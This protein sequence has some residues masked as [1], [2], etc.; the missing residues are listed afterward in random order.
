VSDAQSIVQTWDRRLKDAAVHK[1]SRFG[2][3][4]ARCWRYYGESTHAFM[5]GED[6]EELGIDAKMAK[7]LF[8][9]T[10]AKSAEYVAI[11]APYIFHKVPARTV[12]PRRPT[13]PPELRGFFQ[14]GTP[15]PLDEQERRDR[16][17]AM[18]M[19]WWLNF[20]PSEFDL[21][22]E[23]QHSLVEGMVKGRGL[24][25]HEVFDGGHGP[26]VGSFYI[27]VDDL[28]ID[29][30]AVRLKD[31][32][33]IARKRR[34]PVWQVAREFQY[35]EQKLRSQASNWEYREDPEHE[36]GDT[37]DR[38]ETKRPDPIR[39]TV[40]YYEIYSACGLGHR[41]H[42]PE[43]SEAEAYQAMEAMGDH[44]YLVICPGLDEPLNL[45]SGVMGSASLQ[46]EITQRLAWPIP[47]HHDNACPWLF[48][49]L[50][51]RHRNNC[52]WPMS[53]L[54]PALPLQMFLNLAFSFLMGR[55][56]TT[57]RD[58]IC[59]AADAPAAIKEAIQGGGDREVVYFKDTPSGVGVDISK[60][61]HVLQFP[62]VNKDIYAVIAAAEEAFEKATGMVDL[63]Y[64]SQGPRQMRS[65]AEAQIRQE[66]MTSRPDA[67]AEQF[68]DFMSRAARKEAFATRLY[69]PPPKTLFG[70]E[71]MGQPSPQNPFGGM[72]G[73]LT[74]A[75]AGLVNTP[76]PKRAAL[77]L[78][79]TV[80]AN[81]GRKPNRQRQIENITQAMPIVM[82]P[83]LQYYQMT[84]DPRPFNGMIRKWGEAAD[85]DTA[86]M[87]LPPLPPPPG[88]PPGA[89]QPGP[90]MQGTA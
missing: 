65:S 44:V 37:A 9:A 81:S 36:S 40:E 62:G 25:W 85:M 21:R 24:L 12:Q 77:E 43:S 46:T 84:G 35:P 48:S 88:Q 39:E 33:W 29:P 83:F 28:L 68:E 60:M 79:F 2:K 3:D 63:M 57:C 86:E 78:S 31:A 59:V 75:W 4:A 45:H 32:T 53:P 16:L 61:V 38:D 14:Q 71:M 18:L 58:I 15:M 23:S 73:P 52:V 51:F 20:T 69:I 80:E 17:R 70:E 72:P 54:A 49:E 56:H 76:D 10:L 74:Q 19:E 6:A 90:Q 34:R 30:N 47:W 26:M 55:L 8:R 27:S 66:N 67:M 5:Y 89:P 1:T 82:Q 7:P 13:I 22:G 42:G 11:L 41:F 50:D 87:M 64:G